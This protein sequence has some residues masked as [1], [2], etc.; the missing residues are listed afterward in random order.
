MSTSTSD[1]TYNAQTPEPITDFIQFAKTQPANISQYYTNI[2]CKYLAT[3]I[4]KLTKLTNKIIM[5]TNGGT[6]QYRGSL[7]FILTTANGVVSSYCYGQLAGH[8]QFSFC[9]EACAF[10][11]GTQVVF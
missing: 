1:K 2:V 4:Y 3:E 11:V 6:V 7:S 8:N 10:I 9:S 5:A